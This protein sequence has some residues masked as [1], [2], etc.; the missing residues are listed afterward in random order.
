MAY[1][2]VWCF[3]QCFWLPWGQKRR[4][5]KMQNEGMKVLKMKPCL[6]EFQTQI[7]TPV[8][9]YERYM[10]YIFTTKLTIAIEYFHFVVKRFGV[11]VV[12]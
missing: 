6:Q 11:G 5:K 7:S 1:S 9:C 4:K 2:M 12:K 10:I 3:F 8:M